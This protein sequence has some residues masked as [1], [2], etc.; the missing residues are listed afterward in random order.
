MDRQKMMECQREAELQEMLWNP[1][2]MREHLERQRTQIPL[3]N[4]M[5]ALE[6]QSGGCEAD[7][8]QIEE[9]WMEIYKNH[10]EISKYLSVWESQYRIMERDMVK[11]LYDMS[12]AMAAGFER[13]M[14]KGQDYE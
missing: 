14:Q 10:G 11:K 6:L 13:L 3:A 4:M 7:H 9:I 12:I 1:E 2:L 8:E 5:R